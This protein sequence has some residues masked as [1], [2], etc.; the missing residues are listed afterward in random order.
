MWFRIRVMKTHVRPSRAISRRAM[1]KLKIY[2]DT[3]VISH[4]D[5]QD[6][7]EKMVDTRR[8]W[9]LVKSGSFDVCVSPVVIAEVM[10]CAETKR[11]I[12]LSWLGDVDLTELPESNEVHELAKRYI[13]AG[14]LRPKS[15]DDCQHIA[16]ACVYDC[17]VLVSWNFK[18]MVNTTTIAGVK[19]VNALEGYREMPILTP[20]AIMSGGTIHDS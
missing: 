16:Y 2:L 20:T 17:D 5:H 12:L 10:A 7:P 9:E 13:D 1:K 4:L 15:F 19:G 14:I 6:A 11:I 8:L 18:H 3:S